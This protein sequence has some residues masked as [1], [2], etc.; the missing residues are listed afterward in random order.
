MGK[1]TNLN[2]CNHRISAINSM[3]HKKITLRSRIFHLGISKNQGD[4]TPKMDGEN[5]GSK[6]LWTNGMIWWGKTH[7]YFCFNTQKRIP[8]MAH[9]L[10]Q[11]STFGSKGPS[12]WGPSFHP[13]FT[14]GSTCQ[15]VGRAR[16]PHSL[17][18]ATG[19]TRLVCQSQPGKVYILSIHTYHK[20]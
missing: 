14:G 10:L 3:T 20:L 8:K 16:P 13:V 5:N 7:P 15:S 1:T 9:H 19:Y 12:F 2:W 6:T 11:E 4:F 17:K 18:A